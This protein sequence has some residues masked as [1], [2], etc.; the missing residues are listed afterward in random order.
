MYELAFAEETND[1]KAL[2]PDNNIH[3]H[4]ILQGSAVWHV[5]SHSKIQDEGAVPI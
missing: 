4:I 1:S 3:F 2:G 5:S